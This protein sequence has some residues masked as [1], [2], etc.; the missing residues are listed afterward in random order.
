[1]LNEQLLH[2][3]SIAIIGASNNIA[4]PGGKIVKNLIDNHYKIIFIHLIWSSDKIS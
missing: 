2:P 4:K 3:D 1:M